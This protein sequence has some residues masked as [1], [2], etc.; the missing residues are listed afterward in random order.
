MRKSIVAFIV[1]AFFVI[2][3]VSFIKKQ[4]FD[5]A[6]L[7]SRIISCPPPSEV[8]NAEFFAPSPDD[9]ILV[10]KDITTLTPEELEDFRNAIKRMRK[11]TI[12]FNS[13]SLKDLGKKTMTIWEF[14]AAIH[15]AFL[16]KKKLNK[17]FGQCVHGYKFFLAWHRMYIYYFEKILNSYMPERS[18]T[19]GLPYWD[20]QTCS[21]IPES[22][23]VTDNSNP[24]YDGTRNSTLSDGGYLSGY[25]VNKQTFENSTIY[26]LI[27]ASLK[28]TDFYSFQKAL[29][30]PHGDIHDAVDGNLSRSSTA[31]LDPLFWLNHANVD[32]LWEKWLTKKG[33]RCNPTFDTEPRW[34]TDTFYFY[35]KNKKRVAINGEQIVNIK[36]KLNYKYDNITSV[37]QNPSSC[38]PLNL[39]IYAA[40]TGLEK[41]YSINGAKI[42]NTES[43]DFDVAYDFSNYS[44]YTSLA[45]IPSSITNQAV[46]N[47]FNYDY[48]IE[49]EKIKVKTMPAGVIEMYVA[50]KEQKV[51]SPD[52]KSFVGLFDL[53]TAMAVTEENTY[54]NHRKGDEQDSVYR[55]NI[56]EVIKKVLVNNVKLSSSSLGGKLKDQVVSTVKNTFED[57]KNLRIHFIIRGNILN[58]IEVKKSVDI[59]IGKLSLAAYK[60]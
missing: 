34:R 48:Y 27:E 13:V 11:D 41:K 18:R 31:G 7:R 36:N 15:G 52:D 5:K 57:L 49:F 28:E 2:I 33:K 19:L 53:F 37:T 12:S 20:Y 3:S 10:R 45:F 42:N 21:K 40:V 55:V 47:F 23:R 24:L 30:G 59:T 58:G 6:Q 60:N 35:D 14:Q 16:S 39:N 9:P 17:D 46:P 54:H 22:V 25:D 43:N 38:K 32:R 1:F 4:G 50:N 56:N 26:K 51:F 29:E 8:T 44:S